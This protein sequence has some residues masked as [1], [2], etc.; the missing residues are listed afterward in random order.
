MLVVC[1]RRFSYG[2]LLSKINKLDEWLDVT[3]V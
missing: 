2:Y 3:I 1:L